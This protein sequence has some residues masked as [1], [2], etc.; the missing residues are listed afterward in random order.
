M[1]YLIERFNQMTIPMSRTIRMCKQDGAFNEMLQSN[2][3][4]VVTTPENIVGRTN[5]CLILAS[6]YRSGRIPLYL[7][8][9]SVQLPDV[10]AQTMALIRGRTSLQIFRRFDELHSNTDFSLVSETVEAEATHQEYLILFIACVMRGRRGFFLKKS[11]DI[12]SD[13][14]KEVDITS[15]DHTYGD[16][17]F[18]MLVEAEVESERLYAFE[19]RAID[20]VELLRLRRLLVLTVKTDYDDSIAH[21][22]SRYESRDEYWHFLCKYCIA[23][24]LNE[25]DFPE[26]RRLC[27]EYEDFTEGVVYDGY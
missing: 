7:K 21:A 5:Y 15:D 20:D 24:S 23:N 26:L 3:N 6:A 2:D 14:A 19:L 18:E 11:R 4:S 17:G 8:I 16:E 12:I 25:N 10:I 9:N 27:V 22:Q 13:F 1:E